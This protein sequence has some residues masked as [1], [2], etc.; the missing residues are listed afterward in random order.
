MDEEYEISSDRD[1]EIKA[2]MWK[3]RQDL[4]SVIPKTKTPSVFS[5]HFAFMHRVIA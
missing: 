2:K 3:N 1:V 5:F 4:H